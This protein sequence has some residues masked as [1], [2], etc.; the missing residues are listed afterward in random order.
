LDE[1]TR[2]FVRLKAFGIDPMN[3][4]MQG[5]VD[6]AYKLGGGF[7]EVQGISLA[8]G[9]AWA[10]QKLQG[11]EILQLIERGVPVWEMLE[12]VTGK[13]T[14]EL[15]KMSEA[16]ALGRDT[17]TSLMNVMAQSSAGAAADNMSLLSGLISNAKD[18]IEKFYRM[19][20]DN[21]ALDW[22]KR[23]LSD[24][25]A[26]FDRMLADGSLQK[27]AKQISDGVIS[28][29]EAVKQLISTLIDWK[30]QIATVGQAWIG[31]KIA[32]WTSSVLQFAASWKNVGAAISS[33]TAASP[34]LVALSNPIVALGC[35]NLLALQNLPWI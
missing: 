32:S 33:A 4:T 27:W 8:L 19:V 12:K 3:G 13:N 34:L 2:V 10:K 25:N 22:L 18:N 1:V 17:I 11:E 23:Q 5:I 7:E 35:R 9:Q 6:Q 29:G 26:E 14:A 21:G 28:T 16:G 24:L 20:A 15:Q 30:S 31:L